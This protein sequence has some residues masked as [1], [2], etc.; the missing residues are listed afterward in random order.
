MNDEKTI[1]EL[2]EIQLRDM[3][4]MGIIHYSEGDENVSSYRVQL[5]FLELARRVEWK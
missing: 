1:Q 4:D 2:I 5:F 3:R